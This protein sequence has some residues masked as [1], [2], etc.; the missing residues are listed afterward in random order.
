MHVH[1]RTC[2]CMRTSTSTY[3]RTYSADC[4]T[5]T[6]PVQIESGE[7]FL[8]EEQKRARAEAAKET[9]QARRIEERAKEREAAFVAPKV[10]GRGR[11]G[12]QCGR[13]R[14]ALGVDVGEVWEVWEVWMQEDVEGQSACCAE[15]IDVVG[16]C[17]QSL[18]FIYHV[19]YDFA[20]IRGWGWAMKVS[21]DLLLSNSCVGCSSRV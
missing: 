4:K 17:G 13:V 1:T 6:T 19:F 5:T 12:G 20:G 21:F 7:Y 18:Y 8:S 10:W 3:T 16:K 15:G 2:T 9:K 11:R 14:H